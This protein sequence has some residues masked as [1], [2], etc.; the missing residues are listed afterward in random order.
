M[1]TEIQWTDETWNPVTGCSKV[2]PGCA[3]CYA[4]RV[5]IRLWPTQYPPVFP[6]M[7]DDI[8]EHR[9][10]VFTDVQCHEDRLDAPLRWKK[11]RKVFVNSMSDLFHE[12]VPDAFIDK[13][14]AVMA[15]AQHTFQILTKRA[16]RMRAYM[17]SRAKSA[18]PWKDAARTVGYALEFEGVSLVRFP[19]QNVWLGVSV[20]NQHFADERIPLLLQTPAAVRFISAEPL[21]G[22]LDLRRIKV[23]AEY[24]VTYDALTG[25]HNSES[26]P[27]IRTGNRLDWVIPG[28]ESGFGA[29]PTDIAWIRLLV[30]QCQAAGTAVFVKQLGAAPIDGSRGHRYCANERHATKCNA[31]VLR[32]RK[33]GDMAEW[34]E[35]LRVREMP[36]LRQ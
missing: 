17:L 28:G 12:D 36:A 8:F 20:E 19:L 23:S 21:L 25:C 13:V 22:P 18:Q 11:P 30:Q 27:Q 2:S 29:R 15:L 35:N 32:D 1:S 26:G 10:R 31:V 7:P 14:F 6:G 3:H 24:A 16:E 33:G 9:P 5:A 4:E 34:P